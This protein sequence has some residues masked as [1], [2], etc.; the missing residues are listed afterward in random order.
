M[1]AILVFDEAE[2]LFGS[3]AD[4]MSSSS[5]RWALSQGLRDLRLLANADRVT[6]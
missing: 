3:R 4:T 6:D 5:D 1:D 2:S